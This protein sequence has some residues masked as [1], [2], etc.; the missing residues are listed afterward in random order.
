MCG[1]EEVGL[2]DVVVIVLGVVGVGWYVC[3]VGVFVVEVVVD[4]N[5]KVGFEG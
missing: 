5:D 2:L 4:M 1:F 3:G